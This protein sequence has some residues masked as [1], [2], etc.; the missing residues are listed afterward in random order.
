MELDGR[1]Y[2]EIDDVGYHFPQDLHQANPSEVGNYPLQDHHQHLSGTWHQ[3]F[4]SL[5]GCLYDG[6]KLLPFNWVKVLFLRSPRKA[7]S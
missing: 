2:P 5:E 7:K 3:E 6:N 1:R 4:S